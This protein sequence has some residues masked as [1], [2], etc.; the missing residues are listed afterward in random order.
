MCSFP[1]IVCVLWEP[2]QERHGTSR[3]TLRLSDGLLNDRQPRA[4]G[5]RPPVALSVYKMS[6]FRVVAIGE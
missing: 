2:A 1:C 6:E 5:T 3:T 4:L